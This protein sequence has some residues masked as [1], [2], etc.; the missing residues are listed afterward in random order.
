VREHLALGFSI[1]HR[2]LDR[3]MAY[4]Y[5]RATEPWPAASVVL[6]VADRMATRGPSSRLRHLRRHSETADELLGLIA[7]LR[8]DHA[9][10]LM[11][12][13]EIA[14]ATG[15]R[16]AEIKRLVD[17]LAE[18]QAAGTVAT[19]KEALAYVREQVR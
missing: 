12:G 4:R 2:P 15:A 17:M 14:E 5:L 6:S 11:R 10:P 8:A 9:P 16:A 3:R 7:Q 13:D 1:P 18:E 19:R